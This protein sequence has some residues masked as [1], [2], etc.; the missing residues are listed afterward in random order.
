MNVFGYKKADGM[1]S[2]WPIFA[3]S[4][5]GA[6]V[7][8]QKA[9]GVEQSTLPPLNTVIQGVLRQSQLEDTNDILFDQRYFYTREKVT[10]Y[11]SSDGELKYQEERESTNNPDPNCARALSP[12][13]RITPGADPARNADPVETRSKVRGKPFQRKDFVLNPDLLRHFTLT[14]IGRQ[15]LNGRSAL[16]VDFRPVNGPLPA[17]SIKERFINAAA[18]RLW[19]DEGDYTLARVDLHLTKKIDILGGLAGAVCKFLYSFERERTADG[20]WFTRDV[21]WHFEGREVLI[22]KMVDYHERIG[23]LRELR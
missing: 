1:K 16:V 17:H 11:F 2:F 13:A 23:D 6:V 5:L 15:Q 8:S 21:S 4:I 20:L 7:S 9:H 12:P 19:V 10:D 14:L 22:Q 3:L 18:G